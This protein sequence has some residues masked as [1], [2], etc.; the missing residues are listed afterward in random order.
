MRKHE[1][2]LHSHITKYYLL[3]GDK[4]NEAPSS[5]TN[6]INEVP[7]NKLYPQVLP[8]QSQLP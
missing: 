5:Y 3:F 7:W 1:T 2:N 6:M 8:V 4:Y